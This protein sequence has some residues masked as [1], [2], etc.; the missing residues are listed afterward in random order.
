MNKPP[1][2]SLINFEHSLARGLV[3]C[4]LMNER[5]GN[6]IYDLSGHGGVGTLTDITWKG[7]KTG[8][9]LNNVSA[10]GQIN[11]PSNYNVL[12]NIKE[13]T[14]IT[15][16]RPAVITGDGHIFNNK[17]AD[18]SYMRID[19]GG[20]DDWGFRIHDGTDSVSAGDDNSLPINT[21]NGYGNLI[22]IAMVFRAND[23]LKI[24]FDAAEVKSVACPNVDFMSATA[25][26]YVLINSGGPEY[27][28]DIEYFYMYNRALSATEVEQLYIN[29][30]SMFDEDEKTGL[31]TAAQTT[32]GIV[33]LRRRRECA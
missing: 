12:D 21:Y 28:G 8:V 20:T 13:L 17:A 3:G 19:T 14:M 29:P 33:I 2:G 27:R 11:L 23:T 9:I 25:S 26:N 32:G 22:H 30:Y 24:Y 18:V 16:L 10:T 4:W 7:G 5:T 1:L 6:K 15:S 31:W